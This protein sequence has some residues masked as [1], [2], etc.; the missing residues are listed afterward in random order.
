MK[1]HSQWSQ[2]TVLKNLIDKIGAR[3]KFAVEF[4][5]ADG[6]WLSNIRGF[7]E[8]GWTGLQM[9]GRPGATGEGFRPAPDVHKEFI[10]AENINDLFAKYNVPHNFDILSIDIDGMDYWVWKALKYEPSVV[11]IEFN[12]NFGPDES[13][14]LKYDPNYVFDCKSWAYS[15][16]LKAFQK[17]AKDKG[18]F[19]YD[20]CEWND[21]FF[22]KNEFAD[23]IKPIIDIPKMGLPR[24]IHWGMMGDYN[25]IRSMFVEV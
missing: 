16:S 3:H 24:S 17:L 11:M 4:G 14:A 2:A 15:A 20:H 12:S 7:I 25:T 22:V 5:A 9:D 10:T 23:K 18:Y 13:Y 21:L 1:D 8:L 6:H 19:L